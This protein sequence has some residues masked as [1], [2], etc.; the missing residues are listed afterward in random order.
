MSHR[1]FRNRSLEIDFTPITPFL[2]PRPLEQF[3][4]TRGL[5]PD[6]VCVRIQ[7]RCSNDDD[8]LPTRSFLSIDARMFPK[9]GLF[10]VRLRPQKMVQRSNVLVHSRN[11]I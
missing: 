8:V 3:L 10:G 7:M 5:D 1:S 6:G 9:V 2:G 11:E 4:T